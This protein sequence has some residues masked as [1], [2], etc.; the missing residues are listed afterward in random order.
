M[1]DSNETPAFRWKRDEGQTLWIKVGLAFLV[2]YAGEAILFWEGPPPFGT[3]REPASHI[4][5]AYPLLYPLG[6]WGLFGYIVYAIQR[7]NPVSQ[8]RSASKKRFLQWRGRLLALAFTVGVIGLTF[9]V[10][11]V[12]GNTSLGH[13][14]L[15]FAL[16]L[17]A[18]VVGA[19][20]LNVGWLAA[21]GLWLLTALLFYTYPATRVLIPGFKDEDILIGLVMP[22]GFFLIGRFPMFVD[23]DG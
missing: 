12:S 8:T 19:M 6:F 3:L 11:S 10:M 14:V 16:F 2:F 20:E 22:L 15:F 17:A 21:A 7:K 9:V 13:A 1:S 18:A 5:L 23:R 4:P